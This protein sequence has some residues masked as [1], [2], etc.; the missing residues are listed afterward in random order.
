[1][2]KYMLVIT[3]SNF[4]EGSKDL[5][6]SF[7]EHFKGIN[8]TVEIDDVEESEQHV[9]GVIKEEIQ[10][11]KGTHLKSFMRNYIKRHSFFGECFGVY[12]L[13]EYAKKSG[14]KE[15]LTEMD[16]K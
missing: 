4:F 16:L 1:M 10:L 9:S 7:K 6:K 12:T 15:V 14:R 2:R 13:K 5:E 11:T 3:A 8:R